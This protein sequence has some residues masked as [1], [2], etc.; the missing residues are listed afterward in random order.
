LRILSA[1]DCIRNSMIDTV[2][3]EMVVECVFIEHADG[4]RIPIGPGIW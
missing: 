1:R 2:C 4:L 3:S